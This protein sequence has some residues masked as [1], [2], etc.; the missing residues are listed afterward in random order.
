MK[1]YT[2][3]IISMTL[4]LSAEAFAKAGHSFLFQFYTS[5]NNSNLIIL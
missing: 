3:L 2:N 4:Y 5:K 1:L